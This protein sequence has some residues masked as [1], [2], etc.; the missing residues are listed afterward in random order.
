LLVQAN[1]RKNGRRWRFADG[2]WKNQ[3]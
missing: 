2:T 3:V 1:Q